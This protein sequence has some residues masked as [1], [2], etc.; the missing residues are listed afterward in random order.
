MNNFMK[1]QNTIM[2]KPAFQEGILVWMREVLK[3]RSKP[4][5]T[6]FREDPKDDVNHCDRSK[7]A[8]IRGPHNLRDQGN[9]A[10]IQA[11]HNQCPNVELLEHWHNHRL[12]TIPEF[13]EEENRQAIQPWGRISLHLHDRSLHLTREEWEGEL[14]ILIIR[15]LGPS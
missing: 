6:H 7:L 9:H 13:L 14:R 12:N 10:I 15:D 8:D 11:G 2:D 5:C 4:R 1:R 3:D